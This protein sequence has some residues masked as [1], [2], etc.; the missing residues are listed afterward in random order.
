MDAIKEFLAR[1][2]ST[3]VTH[4]VHQCKNKQKF[5]FLE[6]QEIFYYLTYLILF[7]HFLSLREGKEG[8]SALN[9]KADLQLVAQ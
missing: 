3:K 6:V 9:Y 8:I 2:I 4:I 1:V 5:K 7:L